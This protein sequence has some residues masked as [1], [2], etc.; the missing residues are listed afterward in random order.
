MYSIKYLNNDS[1]VDLDTSASNITISPFGITT[2]KLKILFDDS[3][4]N[5]IYSFVCDIKGIYRNKYNV[6]VFSSYVDTPSV[7]WSNCTNTANIIPTSNANSYYFTINIKS[8]SK[9]ESSVDLN[10]NTTVIPLNSKEGLMWNY[11]G[12]K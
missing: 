10:I 6:K 2:I 1:W 11:T 9:V 7:D 12:V 4:L 8:N 5:N 3:G